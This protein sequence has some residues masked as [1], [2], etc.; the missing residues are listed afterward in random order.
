M[1]LRDYGVK[2]IERIEFFLEQRS[3]RNRVHD[4]SCLLFP[5]SRVLR[6][7]PFLL[8]VNDLPDLL[9]GKILLFAVDVKI[10]SPRSQNDYT[11]LRLRTAWDSS[12]KLDLPLNPDK[13]CHLPTFLSCK[14][15]KSP[16]IAPGGFISDSKLVKK[17]FQISMQAI[18]AAPPQNPPMYTVLGGTR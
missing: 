18:C 12:V 14:M 10:I 1:K 15:R 11:E 16:A 9:E 13:C 17:T 5:T 6:L 2:V 7:L 3:F 8:F 4:C